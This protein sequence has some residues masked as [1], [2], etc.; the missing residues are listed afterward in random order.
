VVTESQFEFTED[1]E[2]L[3]SLAVLAHCLPAVEGIS[4]A[5]EVTIGSSRLSEVL[6]LEM[7]SHDVYCLGR[8]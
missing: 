3:C 1:L 6:P 4:T 5:R 7:R 2:M 8:V